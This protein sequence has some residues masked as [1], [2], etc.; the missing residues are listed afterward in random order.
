MNSEPPKWDQIALNLLLS[1]GTG[2]AVFLLMRGRAFFFDLAKSDE[3]R[4]RHLQM[5]I[6][7]TVFGVVVLGG[8]TLARDLGWRP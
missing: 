1:I 7:V 4:K 2:A 8:A 6:G 5:A 3:I